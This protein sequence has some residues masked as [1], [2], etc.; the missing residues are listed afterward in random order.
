MNFSQGVGQELTPR[1]ES[2]GYAKI[3]APFRL[4]EL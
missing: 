1:W 2:Q 3:P 4:Q